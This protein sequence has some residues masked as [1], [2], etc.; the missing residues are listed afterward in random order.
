MGFNSTTLLSLPF[1]LIIPVIVM[2]YFAFSKRKANIAYDSIAYGFVSFLASL[3]AVFI[4]FILVNTLFLSSLTFEDD[5]SGLGV[6]G[7]IIAVMIA[8]LYIVCE[9]LK[10]ATL[11]KF[12]KSETRYLYAGAGFS[13]GVI[14]AQNAAVF[15]ALN[16]FSQY[17]MEPQY[18]IFSGAIVCLTGIMYTVLSVSSDIAL[19]DS[20]N[21]AVMALSSVYYLFWI[22]AIVSSN[23]T[24]L[25]YIVS[26]LFFVISMIL[27]GI[28]II[29]KH[30][31]S[32]RRVNEFD[33]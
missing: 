12:K 25:I 4:A 22:L 26:A 33:T 15:V 9:S 7:T 8:M 29:G 23:S 6:A 17:E 10:I 30:K 18:A 32:E 3:V 16:I 13:A 27:G 31:K 11:K 24:I 28:F 2:V 20:G 19:D 14:I 1:G 5:T 21:G